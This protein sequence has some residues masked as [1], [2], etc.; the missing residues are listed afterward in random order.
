M[1]LLEGRT[2]VELLEQRGALAPELAAKVLR[3]LAEALTAVH[4]HGI[5]HRDM[6]AENI[7][8]SG[9]PENPF[10]KLL[11]FGV[12]KLPQ[13][14]ASQKLTA[15]GMLVGT[16]EYMCPTQTVSAMAVDHKSDLWALGVVGY[17]SLCV[18]F[19]FTGEKTSDTF[20]GI[21]TGAYRPVSQARPEVG[22]WFDAWFAKSFT[23]DPKL[24]WNSAEE[25]VQ[26]F[27]QAVLG[28]QLAA[29][30]VQQNAKTLDT[31]PQGGTNKVVLGGLAAAAVVIIVLLVVLLLR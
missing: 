14:A 11:D 28:R 1:E 13:A 27:E 22:N 10:V 26:A 2:L 5:V 21:R 19:P 30:G 25:M 9:N 7:F 6:K 3:Q 20:M 12:A 24:R 31:V 18:A 8:L 23:V 17:L 29:A 16:P 4:Q 15:P